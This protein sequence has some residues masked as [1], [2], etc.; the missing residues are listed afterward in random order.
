[1]TLKKRLLIISQI[2]FEFCNQHGRN[3]SDGYWLIG[4]LSDLTLKGKS[5]QKQ[6]DTVKK[7]FPQYSKFFD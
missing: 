2:G 7:E 1:M 6:I 4:M 5:L 3:A